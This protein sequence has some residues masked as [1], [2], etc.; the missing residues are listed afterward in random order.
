M[1]Y[2]KKAREI[3]SDRI[4]NKLDNLVLDFTEI[5]E[6]HV[7]YIIISGYVSILLGR[8]RV[9]EDVDVFIKKISFD[10]FLELYDELVNNGFW[11]INA[12]KA[13]E[14][15]SYLK[16]GL[17]VRFAKGNQAVPNF[18]VKFPKRKVDEEAFEDSIVVTLKKGKLNISCLE[19]HVA[20]KRYFLGTDKDVEDSE[21][22][23]RAFKGQIDYE[24][25]NKLKEI[26]RN[27]EGGKRG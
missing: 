12:E 2:N 14:V 21:H 17:A 20:F 4:L 1:E 26:I 11:C 8:T 19:R 16:D 22:I 7:D 9:T 18:E 10:T 15:F 24:K 27:K 6:K 3:K 25:V 23:E 5:L 13:E